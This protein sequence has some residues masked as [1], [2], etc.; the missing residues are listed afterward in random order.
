[1]MQGGACAEL[2]LSSD[3]IPNTLESWGLLVP[4]YR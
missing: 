3:L 1:M 2:L 4:S